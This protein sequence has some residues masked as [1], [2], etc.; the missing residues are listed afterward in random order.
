MFGKTQAVF[1]TPI[2]NFLFGV[3][4]YIYF[5][6]LCRFIVISTVYT[7]IFAGFLQVFAGIQCSS[8][9]MT[10]PANLQG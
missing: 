7:Y 8:I 10:K 9:F 5:C 2:R 4:L 1:C 6:R 3:R